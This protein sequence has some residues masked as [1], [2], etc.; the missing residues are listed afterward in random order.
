MNQ[1]GWVSLIAVVGWLI[2]AVGAL[3]ARQVGARKL[4]T[5]TVVWLAIF[6]VIALLFAAAGA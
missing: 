6:V 1:Y 5:L 3:R 2:L 4:V